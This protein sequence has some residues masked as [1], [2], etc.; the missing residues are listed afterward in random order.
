VRGPTIGRIDELKELPGYVLWSNKQ[1]LRVV[2]DGTAG[3]T[4]K[5]PGFAG[6]DL[7]ELRMV[8]V[9]DPANP[10]RPSEELRIGSMVFR[11]AAP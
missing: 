11:R 8:P 9:P 1:L 7:V 10:Q 5:A 4:I 6:R 3:M 2:D